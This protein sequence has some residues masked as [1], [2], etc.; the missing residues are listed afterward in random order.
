MTNYYYFIIPIIA[1]I[2]LT[3]IAFLLRR[4]HIRQIAKLEQNKLQIQHKPIFEEMTK[5][6]QLN[7]TGETEEKFERWRYEWTEVMD[8]HMIEIDSLLFDAEEFVDR[9]H[10]G[11]ATKVEAVIEEKIEYCNTKMSEILSELDELV[12]SE[13][14]NRV[15][16]EVLKDEHRTARKKVLAR[17]H[18]FGKAVRPLESELDSFNA[19]FEEY[20]ELTENGNYLQAREIVIALTEKGQTIFPLIDQIPILLTELQ[21]KIPASIRELRNGTREMEEQSYYL[22]HLSIPSKLNKMEN[23]IEDLIG[24]LS[25]LQMELLHEETEKLHNQ[26]ESFYDALE[27]EVI[28]RNFVENYYQTTADKLSD[29][30]KSIRETSKEATFVQQSYRLNEEEAKIP[31]ESVEKLEQL[32]KRFE[33]LSS[34]LE[35]E[36][37]AY[38]SLQ[39]ELQTMTIELEQIAEV[40]DSFVE[41]IKSL[42]NDENSV[43]VEIEK[44]TRKLQD[45]DRSLSRGNIPGIPADMDVRLEEAEE[46][47]YIV[48]QSLEEVPLNMNLVNSYLE[49]AKSS[50]EDVSN[51]VEE[52][53]ENV[54]L[55][56]RIIQYGNRYRTTNQEVH[57]QLLEAEESFREF[58]YTK[59]LEEAAIAV[60]AV[61]PGAMK[62]I[63][64]LVQ[65]NS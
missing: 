14:K 62:R 8:L 48:R 43:R 21:N 17:Q 20:D 31:N 33:Q 44:L 19:L 4:K 29:V 50:I 64:E 41:R 3:I 28:A 30:A 58:R 9:F 56:E 38:S 60:E 40:S 11:K 46:Q 63:E 26:L 23:E 7:M 18:S 65:E 32:E 52:L 1:L 22:G 47:I 45:T 6:K 51:K 12:G 53:L 13:E 55:I 42:R 27:N 5:I 15:E 54:M 37:S 57:M 2:I 36:K 10:Y 25:V 24:K 34:V 35:E 16:I 39:E 49:N 59:A 61:E